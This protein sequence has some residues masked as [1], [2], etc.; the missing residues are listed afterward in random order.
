MDNVS[1]EID[2]YTQEKKCLFEG[3]YYSVRD[4]GAVLRHTPEGKRARANDN[5]WTFGKENPENGYLHLSSVRVHRIVA[6]AFHGDPHDPKYVV[7]HIDSNRKNNR[8]ENLRWLT[9]LENSLLNPVTRKKIEYLCGSI[10][11]FLENPSMLN[12]RQLEP[13]YSWMRTVTKEEAQNCK[14]RMEV[15]A[16]QENKIYQPR[17]YKSALNNSTSL[18][19]RAYKPLNRYEA[20]FGREPGLDITKTLW[21]ATYMFA[22]S[23]FPL[24][25]E[26]FKKDRLEEYF[27]NI[28]IGE[29]F[30]YTEKYEDHPEFYFSLKVLAATIQEDKKT[31][32]VLCERTDNRYGVVGIELYDKNQWFIHYNLGVYSSK[33]SAEHR[34]TETQ[35]L[36]QDQFFN[37]GYRHSRD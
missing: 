5:Q 16:S 8:P 33:E 1:V 17:P 23:Y 12:D 9:R 34:F 14:N 2:N 27:L 6:T 36:S 35:K 4:N 37:E 10:E 21:A 3:E 29:V 20:G 13:N 11:A 7:D 24:C 26:S 30:A 22:P 25:P 28:K 18:K 19:N 15:W 31:I 32:V